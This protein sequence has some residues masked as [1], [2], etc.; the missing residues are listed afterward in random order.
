MAWWLV[1][2]F[3][4][5]PPP[6]GRHTAV[7]RY[8]GGAACP[9][10]AMLPADNNTRVLRVEKVVAYRFTRTILVYSKHCIVWRGC[11]R[12]VRVNVVKG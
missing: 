11:S 7:Y 10:S 3:I 6:P 9:V 4:P 8:T 12:L 1:R 2:T 5:Y